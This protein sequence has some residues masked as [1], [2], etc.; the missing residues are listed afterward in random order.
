M[1]VAGNIEYWNNPAEKIFGYTE[2]EVIG[3]NIDEIIFPK[4]ISQLHR[5]DFHS[6]SNISDKFRYELIVNYTRPKDRGPLLVH[7]RFYYGLACL[8]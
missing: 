1:I 5:E 3:K 4:I 6:F 7:N 8:S 2:K